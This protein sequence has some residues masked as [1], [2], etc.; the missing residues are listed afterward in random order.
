MDRDIYDIRVRPADGR[1]N[2]WKR[3]LNSNWKLVGVFESKFLARR[4]VHEVKQ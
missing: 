2:V 1:V 4:Y 3:K